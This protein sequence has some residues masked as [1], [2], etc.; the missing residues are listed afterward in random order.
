LN[1]DGV[2]VARDTNLFASAYNKPVA[3]DLFVKDHPHR[4]N[5]FFVDDNSDNAWNMYYHFAQHEIKGTPSNHVMSSFLVST[6]RRWK[7]RE[8]PSSFSD[9]FDISCRLAPDKLDIT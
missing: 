5:I 2:L 7:R 3:L 4:T 6:S 8:I 1:S 9:T